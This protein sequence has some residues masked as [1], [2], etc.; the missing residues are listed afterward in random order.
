MSGCAR[1]FGV[2]FVPG[3]AILPPAQL[4]A[5]GVRGCWVDGLEAVEGQDFTALAEVPLRGELRI[6]R[7]AQGV[8]REVMADRLNV[9]VDGRGLVLRMFCG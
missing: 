9:L 3:P 8:T 2:G 4:A 5:R 1:S 6:L 7:P